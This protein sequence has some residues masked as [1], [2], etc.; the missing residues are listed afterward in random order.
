STYSNLM[1]LI[2]KEVQGVNTIYMTTQFGDISGVHFKVGATKVGFT[3]FHRPVNLTERPVDV[4]GFLEQNG[5]QDHGE[6]IC[7]GYAMTYRDFAG[8]TLG[9]AY[10][11]TVCSKYSPTSTKQRSSHSGIVTYLN[12]GHA[13]P[14]SSSYLT[15]A[16]EIGHNFGSPHDETDECKGGADGQFIMWYSATSGNQP[17]NRKFSPCSIGIMSKKL[18]VDSGMCPSDTIPRSHKSISAFDE[19]ICGN[20]IRE[21]DEVCDC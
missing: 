18:H 2:E 10:V 17:N 20:G 11:G 5:M 7:L 1:K 14:T 19:P 9:L 13:V 3:S 16:H 12:H 4:A 15:L 6:K 21:G 8:G